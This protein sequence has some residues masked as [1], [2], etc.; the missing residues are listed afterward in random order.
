MPP[1]EKSTIYEKRVPD[2]MDCPKTLTKTSKKYCRALSKKRAKIIGRFARPSLIK[3]SGFG[4]AYSTA[5][6]K[7]QRAAKKGTRFSS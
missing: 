7:I 5:D 6:K 2:T 4:T 3:G 1:A